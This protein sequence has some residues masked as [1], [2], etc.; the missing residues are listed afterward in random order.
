MFAVNFDDGLTAEARSR[1]VG[2]FYLLEVAPLP[3]QIDREST[4]G[5]DLAVDT[6]VLYMTIEVYKPNGKHMHVCTL[7]VEAQRS[8]GAAAE[9]FFRLTDGDHVA[10]NCEADT[11][12]A[13]QLPT[14][15]FVSLGACRLKEKEERDNGKYDVPEHVR[16]LDRRHIERHGAEYKQQREPGASVPAAMGRRNFV[17]RTNSRRVRLHLATLTVGTSRAHARSRR[18]PAL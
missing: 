1:S 4:S 16:D 18:I 3:A 13:E 9:P 12:F 2:H 7:D 6:Q 15:C 5:S 8:I 11:L 14:T 10:I 17:R